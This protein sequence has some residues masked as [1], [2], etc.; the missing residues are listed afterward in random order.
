MKLQ[1]H[2]PR[3]GLHLIQFELRLWISG[4]QHHRHRGYLGD[5][6]F[7]QLKSLPAQLGRDDAETGGIATWPR[8]TVH[9]TSSD[10]IADDCHDNRYRSGRGLE[11]LGRRRSTCNNDV[12]I[13][14]HKI[15]GKLRK[16]LDSVLPPFP[17]NRDC[18]P[19]DIAKVTQPFEERF[20]AKR[21]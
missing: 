1:P 9:K 12:D 20:G 15:G 6:F 18:L 13:A 7:E 11:C 21:K 8:K 14:P 19:V 4:I 17:F 10:R 16:P 3:R 2:R 5:D